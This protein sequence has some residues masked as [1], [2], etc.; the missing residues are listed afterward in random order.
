M[1]LATILVAAAVCEGCHGAGGNSTTAGTPSIAGQPEIFITNQLI[2]FREGLRPSPIMEPIVKGM[3]DPE[4]IALA[5][6]FS[7]SPVKVLAEGKA[8]AALAKRGNALIAT[9]FCGQCHLPTLAGRD[10]VPRIAAQ[11]ED[12][13][14]A[15][16]QAYR[17]N[18]RTGADTT[19]A[20]VL[21]GMPDEDIK[22][23]A[24]V[25]ARKK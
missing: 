5:K 8:D 15:T 11:R 24:H 3:K 16:M 2:Y 9:M 12:Y 4:V 6:Q 14:L 18:T 23:L 21:R 20:E 19:M 25:L 10:Q 17:D 22:A 13:L 7:K 1:I